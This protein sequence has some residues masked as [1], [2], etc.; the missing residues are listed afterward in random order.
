MQRQPLSFGLSSGDIIALGKS[1][2]FVLG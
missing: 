2:I 1:R